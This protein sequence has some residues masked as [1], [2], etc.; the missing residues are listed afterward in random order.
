M[1]LWVE[2]VQPQCLAGLANGLGFLARQGQGTGQI[3]AHLWCSGRK[4]CCLFQRAA[5]LF[6]TTRYLLNHAKTIERRG[7]FWLMGYNFLEMQCCGV[8]FAAA[9]QRLCETNAGVGVLG[10]F[11]KD[12]GVKGGGLLEP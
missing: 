12:D 6:W 2:W 9:L 8:V 1:Q 3:G 7:I 5:G 10:Q 4:C 11:V